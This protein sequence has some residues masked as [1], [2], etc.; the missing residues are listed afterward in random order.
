[1]F[2]IPL[3]RSL[4]GIMKVVNIQHAKTHLSKYVEGE[5]IVIAKAGKPLVR[6]VPF[7]D[8]AQPRVL[9][10]LAGQVRESPDCWLA[11]PENLLVV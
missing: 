5:K 2:H 6:L 8:Q 9:G 7:Q 1:M 3:R 11:D 4:V 10:V